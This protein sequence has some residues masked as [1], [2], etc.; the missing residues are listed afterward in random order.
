VAGSKIVGHRVVLAPLV[1]EHIGDLLE[2][3]G[4]DESVDEWPLN[5]QTMDVVSFE[6][7]LWRL[8]SW[9][10]AILR[11]DNGKLVGLLQ[12]IDDDLRNRTV[13]VSLVVDRS[14]RRAGW[15]LEAAVLFVD[16]ALRE[17][18]Y[19]KVYFVMSASTVRQLGH[20]VD[21]WLSKEAVLRCHY[22]AHD[23]YDDCMFYSLDRSRWLA[24]A[25]EF[26]DVAGFLPR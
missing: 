21:R 13:G 23:H 24:A 1:R 16:L 26:R 9:Q 6:E 20:T 7:Y 12:A 19:R 15:P 22:R 14:A 10:Y 18:D 5:G 3:C 8:S 25:D 2:L 4:S 11:R 17:L